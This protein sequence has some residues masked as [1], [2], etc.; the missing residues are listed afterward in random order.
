MSTNTFPL[1]F[2]SVLL[3]TSNASM[4]TV[5]ASPTT[6]I[7]QDLQVKITNV[8]AATR[9]VTMYALPSGAS[10][11]DTYK[12]APEMSVPPFDFIIV[13]VPRL[14]AGGSVQGFADAASSLTVQ[15]IGGKLH[16]P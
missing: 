7:L 9:Q 5:P 12:I 13:P 11:S 1:F 10:A 8:T 3:G 6:I 4:Y 16:T 15:P 14:S 2:N